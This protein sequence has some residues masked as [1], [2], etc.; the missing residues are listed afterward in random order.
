MT[1]NTYALT[2]LSMRT[3]I[4]RMKAPAFEDRII[5]AEELAHRARVYFDL[6]EALTLDTAVAPYEV[7]LDRFDDAWRFT[8]AAYEAAFLI[9]ISNLFKRHKSTENFPSLIADARKAKVI[10]QTIEKQC[11]IMLDGLG[12]LPSRVNIVRDNAMAHQNRTLQQHEAFGQA[13]LSLDILRNYSDVSIVIGATLMSAIG[14]EPR[15]SYTR[16]SITLQKLLATLC[17]ADSN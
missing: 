10:D 12:D 14:L 17:K 1:E 16:P 13:K 7:A 6:W 2:C 9:R 4:E 3:T 8:R 15:M 11:G 5:R